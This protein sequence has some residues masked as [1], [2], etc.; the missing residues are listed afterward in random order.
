[1][2][3]KS[4]YGNILPVLSLAPAARVTGTLNG[5][6][7]DL[8]GFDSAVATVAFGAYTDGVHTPKL[9]ESD[10][11][12]TFAD[13]EAEELDGSFAAVSSAGGAGSVQKVGYLGDARYVRVVMG[14][15]GASTGALSAAQV[16]C[17]HPHHAPV[18]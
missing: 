9:Q 6:S 10:D 3:V 2:S 8:Q 17:G 4:L 11:N 18:A 13:V 1:M 12:V 14:V 15:T 7:V 16:I 5:V